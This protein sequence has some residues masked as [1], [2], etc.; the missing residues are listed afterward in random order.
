MIKK[1][2]I[3]IELNEINFDVAKHYAERFRLRNFS[4]LISG[5]S[6]AVTS[7]EKNYAELEPWIQWVSVHTGLEL[8]DHGVFRLGDIVNSDAPQIFE[9]VEAAGNTVGCVS[10]MNAANR[11]KAP[12][13]FIPDPWTL[14]PSDA[15]WWSR[16]LTGAIGQ[17]VNDNAQSK[18]TLKSLAVLF[19]GVVRFARFG[20]YRHYLRL[21]LT[22][23]GRPW[24]KAL[25]LDLL[26]HDV[27]FGLFKRREPGFSTLFLNAG[28]HIQHHYFFN[29]KLLVDNTSRNPAWYVAGDEDPMADMFQVY[30]SI[31]GDYLNLPGDVSLIVAT[32][33]TQRPYHRVQYYYRLKDHQAFLRSLGIA[34][35]AVHPRMTRDFLI[36]FE[37][38]DAASAAQSC[39]KAVVSAPGG[40]PIFEE[41]DNRG[42]S[43]FVT[44]TYSDEI[45][46]DFMVQSGGGLINLGRQVSFV[47]IKNGMH[48]PEGF[49]FLHGEVAALAPFDGAHV[50]GL[51]YVIARF[52]GLNLTRKTPA[53]ISARQPVASA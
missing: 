16:A 38:V 51:F 7:S 29:T 41:V 48:D 10:A 8:K 6:A 12:A 5:G 43:L 15:S 44:L 14:T 4:K 11:L 18:I 52:F 31:L 20:N 22:S 21:A 26:L 24:R 34:F 32:G 9:L 33:L 27:H 3:L 49:A 1:Q 25:F 28:A 40:K 37:S 39:L 30:D 50:S 45:G 35:R 47:A 36:E 46:P 13:Y 23:R 19:A 17:A 2:L 53:P 42:D